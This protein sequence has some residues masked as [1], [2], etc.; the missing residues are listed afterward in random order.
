[1]R[2]YTLLCVIFIMLAVIAAIPCSA[3]RIQP[4]TQ[5]NYYWQ[6]KGQPVL[7][8]GGSKEDNLFQEPKLQSH[9]SEISNMGVN[10]IRNTMSDRPDNEY[11]VRAFK[12]LESGLYDLNQ[13]NSEYWTRFHNLLQWSK[14]RNII[15][16]IEV[17]DRFDFWDP[18]G[19]DTHPFNPAMNIN[20]TTGESGLATSY[21]AHPGND[22]QPFF[23]TVPD[24]DN[25]LVVLNFQQKFVD[26]MLSYSL[27]YGN[28]L[29]TMN[30]ETSTDPKWGEY[31]IAHIQAKAVAAGVDV[32]TTDMFDEGPNLA[33]IPEYLGVFN[34]PDI[35]TF[36]DISQNNSLKNSAEKHW[37]NILFVR[38]R[39]AET[40]RPINNTKIYGSDEWPLTSYTQRV[41]LR[42]GDL[43]GTNSFWM[44]LLGG[45]ASS[46]FH[47]GWAGLNIRPAAQVN[48]Q[49]AH[50]LESVIKLWEIEPRNDLLTDRGTFVVETPVDNTVIYGEAYLAAK[51]GEKYALYFTKGGSVG[52]KLDS[53]SETT[54]SLKWLNLADGNWDSDRETTISGGNTVTISAPTTDGGWVAALV[55]LIKG[56]LN[57]DTQVNI[58]DMQAMVNHI[59]GLEDF[60][61]AAD[62]NEDGDIDIR[63]L[64]SIVN[65]ILN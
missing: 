28:V 52:L 15:V 38:E 41:N 62:V 59:L 2:N 8:L 37:A 29:Y 48:F 43:A 5:N 3:D 7:L 34:N 33:E 47:R 19:W 36:I 17:W 51:P 53:Y 31:W 63:D 32:Y 44:N 35:H 12:Q 26:K 46:R 57:R 49:A 24:M 22:L 14:E 4:Y 10:Y 39:I 23:H 55:I 61:E 58:Q 65:I 1:M 64:Q 56:D 9:L 30:N 25:N 50:K 21:P 54:F 16:Q 11:E 27:P 60:G 40:P 6:Y 20:Y 42:W 18:M 45:C 13:W